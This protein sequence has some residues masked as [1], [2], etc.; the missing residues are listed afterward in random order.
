M[1]GRLT[2]R[3]IGRE[4]DLVQAARRLEVLAREMVR[5]KY[6]LERFDLAKAA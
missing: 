6:E 5:L 2:P 1:V 4:H 3:L